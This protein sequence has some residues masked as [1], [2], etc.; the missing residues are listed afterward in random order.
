[1]FVSFAGPLFITH[2]LEWRRSMAAMVLGGLTDRRDQ[3]DHDCRSYRRLPPLLPPLLTERARF[4]APRLWP[5][6]VFAVG[7]VGGPLGQFR[8]VFARRRTKAFNQLGGAI[9]LIRRR[10]R[11]FFAFLP[12][13][14]AAARPFAFG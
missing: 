4:A 9:V 12:P 5:V 8:V 7:R 11:R 2:R 3:R 14:F 13:L 6:L 10:G 1:M